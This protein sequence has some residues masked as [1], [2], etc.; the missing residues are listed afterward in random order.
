MNDQFIDDYKRAIASY[1]ED[2]FAEFFRLAGISD[3]DKQLIGKD[4]LGVAGAVYLSQIDM[5][6]AAPTRSDTLKQLTRAQRASRELAESLSQAMTDV[7]MSSALENAGTQ[8]G[9]ALKSSP[10]AHKDSLAILSAIFPVEAD[11]KGFRYDGFQKS[12]SILA[13]CLDQ[14]ESDAI[15][16]NKRGRGKALHPWLV[17]ICMYWLEAKRQL[18]TTGHYDKEIGDYDSADIAALTFAAERIDKDI[19]SRLIVKTLNTTIPAFESDDLESLLL[20]SVGFGAIFTAGVSVS[21]KEA[22]QKWLTMPDGITDEL[23]ASWPASP[24]EPRERAKMSKD[25]FHETLKS[26][27]EGRMLLQALMAAREL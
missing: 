24:A 21:G 10:G 8:A 17:L 2:D 4:F 19:S 20:L 26:S 5:Q 7:S 1:S 15:K 11:G 12:L 6:T 14:I 25:E 16:K 9:R 13:D 18:P 27:D 23:W 3:P 22:M